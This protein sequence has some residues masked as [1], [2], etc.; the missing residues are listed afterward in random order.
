MDLGFEVLAAV[1]MMISIFFGIT[2]CTQLQ[3]DRRFG[4]IFLVSLQ[5]RIISQ[6]NSQY[7]SALRL[8]SWRRLASPKLLLTF[9]GLP[10]IICQKIEE[11]FSYQWRLLY[12]YLWFYSPLLDLGRFFSFLI[13]LH[14]RYN[15]LDRG[16]ARRKA[17]TCTQGRTNSEWTHT[18]IHALSGTWTH[19]PS[20]RAS[21]SSSCLRP[22]GYCDQP[23]KATVA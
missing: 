23:I 15:S 13:F 14:S 16:S 5:R 17:A 11:I 4:G 9:K 1:V 8:Y 20:V 7:I 12:I 2:T 21:E 6:A 22:R 3:V 18:D 19:Y 10:S